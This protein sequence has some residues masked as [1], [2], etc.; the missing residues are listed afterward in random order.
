VR[1]YE[2]IT[3]GFIDMEENFAI[4][5]DYPS[6]VDR[7]IESLWKLYKHGVEQGHAFYKRWVYSG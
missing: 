1:K 3:F 6:K 7:R 5:L 2:P 4:P